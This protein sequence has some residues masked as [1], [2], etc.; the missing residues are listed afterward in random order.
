MVKAK[1]HLNTANVKKAKPYKQEYGWETLHYGIPP[2]TPLSLR[3]LICLLLYTDYS[4]HCNEFSA[5]FRALNPFEP[6][7]IT[8]ERNRNYWW[9]S[10]TLRET[11]ELYGKSRG[12][13]NGR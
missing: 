13:W 5:S 10:K 2:D 7:E 12:G 11:V 3:N 1:A 6:M 8:K 4:A 9:M